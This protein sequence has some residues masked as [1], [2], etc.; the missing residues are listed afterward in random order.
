VRAPDDKGVVTYPHASLINLILGA[1]F[2]DLRSDTASTD[3]HR[4]S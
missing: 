3:G 2:F 4:A 1:V